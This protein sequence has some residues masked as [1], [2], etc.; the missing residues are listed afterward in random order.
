MRSTFFFPGGLD[1]VL[2]GGPGDEDAVVTPEVPAGGLIGQAVLGHQADGQILDAAGV[3]APGQ[4]Q[5][6]Q[7]GGEVEVA[8]TAVMAGEGDNEVDGAAGTRVA[9]VVQATRRNGVTAGAKAAAGATAGL[10]VAAA[11]FDTGLGKV[12]D[13]GNALGDVGDVLA[14]SEH[15]CALLT[16]APLYL[17]F[18][19]IRPG[20]GPLSTLKCPSR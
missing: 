11:A 4:G 14:W 20:F 10:V 18:T 2:D 8:V 7:L 6:G 17:H 13:G 19:P 12:L 1:P 15:G 9:Q 16:Q 5:V 3:V